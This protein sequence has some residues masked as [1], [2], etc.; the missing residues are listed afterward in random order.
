MC[1]SYFWKIDRP[2]DKVED[3]LILENYYVSGLLTQ[4][5]Y[6]CGLRVRFYGFIESILV[7]HCY[8]N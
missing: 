7:G 3:N 5:S 4:E 8:W 1:S 2:A 6:W